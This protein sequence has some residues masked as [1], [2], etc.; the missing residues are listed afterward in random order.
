MERCLLETAFVL[1]SRHQTSNSRLVVGD[2]EGTRDD[3]ERRRPAGFSVRQML[4]HEVLIMN[5]SG[6][7]KKERECLGR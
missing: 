4:T 6:I 5:S 2:M 1:R 7:G 3:G